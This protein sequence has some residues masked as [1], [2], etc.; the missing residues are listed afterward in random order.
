M[1]INECEFH[2]KCDKCVGKLITKKKF[3]SFCVYGSDDCTKCKKIE[4]N[5]FPRGKEMYCPKCYFENDKE[6]LRVDCDGHTNLNVIEKRC[7]QCVLEN[8]VGVCDNKNCNNYV[9]QLQIVYSVKNLQDYLNLRLKENSDELLRNYVKT[10]LLY[11]EAIHKDG[12][13]CGEN[14]QRMS[15]DIANNKSH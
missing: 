8:N 9:S 5:E 4:L 12:V 1:N 11:A 2:E 13:N 6:V 15:N 10:I 3:H 14:Y 7:P